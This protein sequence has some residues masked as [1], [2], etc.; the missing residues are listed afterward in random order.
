M[1][2]EIT[3]LKDSIKQQESYICHLCDCEISESNCS[4]IEPE[5]L[6]ED[7]YEI[8]LEKA[9]TLPIADFS[10]Q[11]PGTKPFSE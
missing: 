10:I 11:Y 7:C 8:V 3:N 2:Q 5:K 9:K 1:H 4:T 6:C